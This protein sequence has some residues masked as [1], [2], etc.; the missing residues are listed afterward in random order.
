M[1]ATAIESL[2]KATQGQGSLLREL[3]SSQNET[4]RALGRIYNQ[5]ASIV[6]SM[7][8]SVERHATSERQI[9]AVKSV[10]GEHGERLTKIEEHIG[11]R[12]P[13]ADS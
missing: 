8:K 9:R 13:T 12:A 3:I 5:N 6:E 4:N 11:F 1:L 7:E 2:A 10:Q